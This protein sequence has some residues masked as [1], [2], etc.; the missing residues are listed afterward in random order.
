MENDKS[1]WAGR[2]N[3]W[4]N[5]QLQIAQASDNEEAIIQFARA[6]FLQDSHHDK[7][8]YYNLLKV[9]VPEN[10]WPDYLN[11]LISE[12]RTSYSNFQ[13]IA[14]F[15]VAEKW[16]DKLFNLVKQAH[17]IDIVKEYEPYLAKEYTPELVQLYENHIKRYLSENTGRN[18]YKKPCEKSA[19]SRNSATW[20]VLKI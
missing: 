3:E 6:L 5:W 19:G 12:M 17:S 8:E 4:R 7:M 15:Y 13:H 10:E 9:R 11:E 2:A 20:S 18:Y 14:K 1:R 16:Y